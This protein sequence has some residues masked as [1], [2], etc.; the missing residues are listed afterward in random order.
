VAWLALADM[1]HEAVLSLCMVVT[2]VAI[3]TPLMLLL[4]LRHGSIEML[5]VRLVNNPSYREV[6][7]EATLD[8]NDA[9]FTSL[10]A[11][12]DVA[13]LVPTILRGNSIIGVRLPGTARRDDV[14]MVSTASGDPVL[15]AFGAPDPG[16]G[17]VVLAR[18]AADRLGD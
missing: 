2:L 10:R 5:R 7:P 18:P 15:A 13:W 11:R 14:D 4:G 3:I 9:W 6:W 17:E 16:P 8:L 12:P 1:R